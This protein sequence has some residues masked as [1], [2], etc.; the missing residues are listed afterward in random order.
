MH[1]ASPVSLK[2]QHFGL[3]WVG[4]LPRERTMRARERRRFVKE[5]TQWWVTEFRP[6][7][8]GV[9]TR[10]EMDSGKTEPHS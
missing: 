5:G 1:L 10:R 3:D 9:R 4:V 6:V 8:E 7:K 2:R